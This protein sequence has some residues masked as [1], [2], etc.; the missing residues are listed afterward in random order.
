MF[1]YCN[2]K[3][4]WG[5]QA[6]DASTSIKGVKL[7]LDEKQTYHYGPSMEANDLLQSMKKSAIS[8]T[9]EY[10]GKLVAHAKNT[11]KRRFGG[12]LQ[13]MELQFIM[14]VPAVWSDKAKD[15]TMQAAR[16]AGI[17][18]ADLFLVSEPEAAAVYAIRTI[19]PNTMAVS[20]YPS[21]CRQS[22]DSWFFQ[23]PRKVTA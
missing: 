16:M 8:A 9:G 7:L 6:V 12:A 15:A 5:Y 14:T 11:L 10:V 20:F 13:T 3:M 23:I 18:I 19:Q 4:Q 21:S 2:G 17:P 22:S 1:N